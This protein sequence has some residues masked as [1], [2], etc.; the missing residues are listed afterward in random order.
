LIDAGA[1]VNHTNHKGSNPFNVFCYGD[2][3]ETHSLQFAEYLVEH[4]ADINKADN[5]H[6]TPLL[7]ACC[8]GRFNF[9]FFYFFMKQIYFCVFFFFKIKSPCFL[10]LK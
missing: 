9:I 10:F 5:R 6:L 8:S 1:D 2:S 7:A 3:P 4:G